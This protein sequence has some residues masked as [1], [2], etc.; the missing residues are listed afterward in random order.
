MPGRSPACGTSALSD[1][2]GISFDPPIQRRK[3]VIADWSIPWIVVGE[4]VAVKPL[5]YDRRC[6]K[7]FLRFDPCEKTVVNFQVCVRFTQHNDA[8]SRGT[9]GHG[10]GNYVA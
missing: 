7:H 3:H 8:A 4:G 9:T 1:G 5:N 10:H 2:L 6:L